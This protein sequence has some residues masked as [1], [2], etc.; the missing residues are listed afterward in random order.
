MAK[1]KGTGKTYNLIILAGPTGIGKTRVSLDLAEKLGGEIISMDSMQVYRYMDIGTAKPGSRERKRIPHHLIDIVNPDDTYNT[2]RFIRDAGKAINDIVSRGNLP[3]LVGGTGLYMKGLLEGI[4]PVPH[5]PEEIRE[6]IKKKLKD[7]GNKELYRKL[8]ELDPVTADRISINDSQRLVR[9]LEIFETTGRPWSEFL[10]EDERGG[11]QENRM[12]NPLKL[13]LNCAREILY[14]H[15]NRRTYEMIEKGLVQE[16]ESL[17]AM[18]YSPDL[19]ALQAI[20]YQHMIKYLEGIWDKE[21]AVD[22]MARDT[23]RYAKRQLTW[24][25]GDNDIHWFQPEDKRLLL[26]EVRSWLK[27]QGA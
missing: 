25:S 22:L 12:Y 6:K 9:A 15:I 2:G 19:P 27:K 13:C 5:V 10:A 18:G 21:E 7:S 23:R 17:L 8:Q 26:E 24:F 3:L 1:R 20:G 4:T 16:V 14:D 11:H